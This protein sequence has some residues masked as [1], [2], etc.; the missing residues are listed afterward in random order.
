MGNAGFYR[1]NR[2]RRTEF[3]NF[4]VA[5]FHKRLERGKIHRA[6]ARRSMVG[7]RI[8]HVVNVKS[9]EARGE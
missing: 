4:D 1:F 2:Q 5:G 7:R 3:K 9:S 8:L 6:G